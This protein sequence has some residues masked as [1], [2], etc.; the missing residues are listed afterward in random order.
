MGDR[1]DEFQSCRTRMNARI[2]G[3]G[4]LGLK[5]FFN[6]DTMAYT[7]GALAGKE[8][9]LPGLV[10]SRVLRYSGCVDY[11]SL[12]C[13]EAAGIAAE[14]VGTIGGLKEY[15]DVDIIRTSMLSHPKP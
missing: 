7:D 3:L 12:Q 13:V 1:L 15:G 9:D 2:A 11:P 4:H 5:R 10:A 6:P 8:K 14:P